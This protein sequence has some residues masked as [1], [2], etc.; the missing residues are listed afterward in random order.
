[1]SY[2]PATIQPLPIDSAPYAACLRLPPFPVSVH[3][4]FFRPCPDPRSLSDSGGFSH[5]G[6]L[7]RPCASALH[8]LCSAP[9]PGIFWFLVSCRVTI[10]AQGR[11]ARAP[12]IPGNSSPRS[13]PPRYLDI[14][15]TFSITG[16]PH[17]YL[18]S[19]CRLDPISV[20]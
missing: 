3:P 17:P 19:P 16:P 6:S 18:P 1:M 9:T 8:S 4:P 2:T 12:T 10:L 7:C 15:E 13:L 14:P 20:G 5:F 11:E